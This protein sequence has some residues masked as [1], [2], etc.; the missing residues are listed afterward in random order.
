M[1]NKHKKKI[2][3]ICILAL[4]AL[5]G[6]FTIDSAQLYLD[7]NKKSEQISELAKDIAQQNAKND[8][9]NN[10]L[11][12]ENESEYFEQ[13]ARKEFNYVMPGERIYANSAS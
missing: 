10:V 6:Y 4:I 11:N 5:V 3:I 2:S 1:G 7:I 12:N 13:Y 9:L 8:R